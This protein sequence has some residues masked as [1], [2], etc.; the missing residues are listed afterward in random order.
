[1]PGR[2][3]PAGYL[4]EGIFDLKRDAAMLGID[5]AEASAE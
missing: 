5:S 4:A 1:M 3:H 2:K